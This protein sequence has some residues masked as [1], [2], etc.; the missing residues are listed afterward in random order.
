MTDLTHL[1]AIEVSRFINSNGIYKVRIKSLRFNE[2]KLIA[3]DYEIDDTRDIAIAW[4]KENDYKLESYGMGKDAYI[5]MS[6]T[7]LPVKHAKI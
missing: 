6:S 4:F 2:S 7:F 5:F 3:W 1:H